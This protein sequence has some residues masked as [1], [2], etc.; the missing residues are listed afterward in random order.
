M[1]PHIFSVIYMYSNVID[2]TTIYWNLSFQR[3]DGNLSFTLNDVN[4]VLKE[5]IY[6]TY[7]PT[8]NN[9][10]TTEKEGEQITI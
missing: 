7:E 9:N 6:D 2:I 4:N 8:Y 1:S 5:L 10:P 3:S